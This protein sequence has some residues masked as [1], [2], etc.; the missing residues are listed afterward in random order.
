MNGMI[1][2]EL[3]VVESIRNHYDGKKRLFWTRLW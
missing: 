1:G 2:E 3:T